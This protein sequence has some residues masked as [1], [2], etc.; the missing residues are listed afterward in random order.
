MNAESN[1]TG[2]KI[3]HPGLFSCNSGIHTPIL[4]SFLSFSF[5]LSFFLFLI[6]YS[7]SYS[8]GCNS[9]ICGGFWG[10]KESNT[11]QSAVRNSPVI[12]APVIFFSVFSFSFLVFFFLFLPTSLLWQLAFPLMSHSLTSHASFH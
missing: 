3:H 9:F 5:C 10:G 6:S 7:L 12:P 4:R 11:A 8:F 2:K 1:N